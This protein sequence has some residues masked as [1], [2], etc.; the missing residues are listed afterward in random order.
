M[1]SEAHGWYLFDFTFLEVSVI[2]SEMPTA[3]VRN[4]TFMYLSSN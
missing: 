2:P 4:D 3:F 1:K